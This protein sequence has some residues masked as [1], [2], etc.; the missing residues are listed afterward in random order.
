MQSEEISRLIG[1]NTGITIYEV[2]K[3][4]IR[5]FTDAT[6]DM[7][8]LYRHE[9]FARKSQFGGIVAPPGFFGWPIKKTVDSALLVEFPPELISALDKE[10][11]PL[12]SALD[13]GIEFEYF[14]PVRA[15]DI[16]SATSTLK[17]LRE[18]AK[19]VFFTMET[20]YLNQHGSKVA[21]AQAQYIL[22]QLAPATIGQESPHA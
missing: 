9:E 15:G 14:L 5:R 10:G 3:G 7:N 13:G 18:R 11:Y 17:S 6:G 19:M 22:R 4:A 1:K 2:E 21:T 8:P 12:A 16:L 20:I